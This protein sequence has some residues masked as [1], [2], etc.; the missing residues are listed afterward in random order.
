MIVKKALLRF[1]VLVCAFSLCGC[2]NETN[3]SSETSVEE[4][5]DQYIDTLP[6]S[7]S[8]G[9][10]LHAFTWKYNDIAS[11]LNEIK[12][13][14]YRIVQTSPVTQPKSN[15][16]KWEYFYQPLSYSI[17]DDSPLGTKSDL[18]NL[19]SE[20][21]KLEISII[22][23]IVFNHM[24][25]TGLTDSE[26]FYEVDP[27]VE[28]YEPEIYQNRNTYFH[29][30]K[31]PVGS[32]IVTQ[33]YSGLPD[34]DTSNEYIQQRSLSLLKE[35]IDVG[36]DGF[37]FDAAKHI[38]TPD[39]PNYPSN[40]W[41]NTL[42]KAKEY[43]KEKTGNDLFAYGEILN[44]LEGGRSDYSI[45]SKYMKITDNGFCSS[46][47]NSIFGKRDGSIAATATYTKGNTPA[48]SLIT[49]FE[50]HDTYLSSSSHY[51]DKFVARAWAVIA[52]RNDTN[53]LFFARPDAS[54]SVGK[55][56][57]YSFES[58]LIAVT[59][60]F[61]NRFVCSKEYLN[62]D[63]DFYTCEKVLDDDYGALIIDIN[64][65]KEA[66]VELNNIPTGTYWDSLT[67]KMVTVNNG[68]ANIEFD[69]SR[70]CY[71]T[72]TKK[73]PRPSISLSKRNISFA[74]TLNVDIS[75]TN[76]VSASYQI[77]DGTSVA[78]NE[79]ITIKLD[80]SF[81]IDSKINL[82]VTASNDDY[83]K[84]ISTTYSLFEL[85]DGGFNIVNLSKDLLNNYTIYYWAW[86]STPGSWHND[87]TFSGDVM[88]IDFS[89]TNFTSFLLAVFEKGHTITNINKW[90]ESCLAQT[91][92]I[93]INDGFYDA[94]SFTYS[95]GN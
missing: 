19:C 72:K 44:D 18:E 92:D 46:I 8:D 58:E 50:S 21:H 48:S 26:G 69:D 47:S 84:E 73:S 3:S 40:F 80:K 74:G 31:N 42:G 64:G 87:Y 76:A 6:E 79:K 27:Q 71:L 7:M 13:A 70:I 23:D 14:G 24:A 28:K 36:V 86:G 89:K 12:D 10:I 57:N 2:G 83:S 88:L 77:N 60:R 11:S 54:N 78:F 34:I 38:E 45:Y 65:K 55:I 61:H 75:V 52:S 93:L 94:S 53:P 43:Y 68:K 67:G 59:N 82:K 49:W 20:A 62:G 91:P 1:T 37:R 16:V 9:V 41:P 25:T 81:A 66:E 17:S 90:D 4:T 32:G 30:I 29:R 51:A 85:I 63:K 33:Q 15:G 95:G 56:G 35:C 22:V 5:S 39:D